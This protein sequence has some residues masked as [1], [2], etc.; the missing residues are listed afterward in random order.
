LFLEELRRNRKSVGD[1]SAIVLN[2]DADEFMEAS[3]KTKQAELQTRLDALSGVSP[4][5]LELMD[6]REKCRS[7]LGEEIAHASGEE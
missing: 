1:L 5:K 7:L 2:L 3:A 4:S 6:L